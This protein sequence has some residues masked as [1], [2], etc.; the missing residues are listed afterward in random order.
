[1]LPWVCMPCGCQSGSGFQCATRFHNEVLLGTGR[2]LVATSNDFGGN[3]FGDPDRDALRNLVVG[4]RV[5]VCGAVLRFAA[6]CSPIACWV[7]WRAD[8][9]ECRRFPLGPQLPLVARPLHSSCSNSKNADICLLVRHDWKRPS[10]TQSS[11][12]WQTIEFWFP[13]WF[14]FSDRQ[15]SHKSHLTSVAAASVYTMHLQWYIRINAKITYQRNLNDSEHFSSCTNIFFEFN[16]GL[17]G[18]TL[19]KRST[20]V[21][22]N[23]NFRYQMVRAL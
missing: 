21:Q 8:V 11:I 23:H 2:L 15:I 22:L 14:M 4:V 13:G 5:N 20:I 7:S 9:W 17:P 19:N 6:F 3:G 1:M 12:M 18:Y 16:D 10:K